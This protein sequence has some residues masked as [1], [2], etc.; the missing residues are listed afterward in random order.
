MYFLD[1]M[2]LEIRILGKIGSSNSNWFQCLSWMEQ[3]QMKW[4]IMS[5]CGS[6]SLNHIQKRK[7]MHT[8]AMKTL[9][10]LEDFIGDIC[11]YSGKEEGIIRF[12]YG[13][14]H[15]SLAFT[16]IHFSVFTSIF[17]SYK[18]SWIYCFRTWIL[19]CISLVEY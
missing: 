11:H 10:L 13:H 8:I 14:L 7:M 5:S 16:F 4:Y 3:R 15:L 18:P 1:M 9:S 2:M 12:C 6:M 19:Q 17:L